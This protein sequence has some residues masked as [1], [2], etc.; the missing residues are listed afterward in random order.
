MKENI[1]AFTEQLNRNAGLESRFDAITANSKAEL[2]TALAALSA[3][4]GTPISEAEWIEALDT[5]GALS[6]DVL[7]N[8][9]GGGSAQPFN[10]VVRA[11]NFLTSGIPMWKSG[12]GA[13]AQ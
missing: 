1:I 9:S 10:I 11:K 4:V 5:D 8:V 3:E 2:A 13:K 12:V 6:D 7:E